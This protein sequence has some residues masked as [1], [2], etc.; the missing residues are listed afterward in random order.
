MLLGTELFRG[1][2]ETCNP[3]VGIQGCYSKAPEQ[4]FLWSFYRMALEFSEDEGC[5]DVCNAFWLSKDNERISSF[6]SSVLENTIDQLFITVPWKSIMAQL[7]RSQCT[8][9]GP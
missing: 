4:S 1:F 3:C 9:A 2:V 6:E 8:D 5:E 7:F